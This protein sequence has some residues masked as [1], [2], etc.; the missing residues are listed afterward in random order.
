MYIISREHARIYIYIYIYIYMYIRSREPACARACV[1]LYT[2]RSMF[3]PNPPRLSGFVI[4]ATF[5]R[6]NASAFTRYS[7]HSSRLC[8]NQSSVHPPRPP[9]L[10]TLLQYYDTINKQYKTPLGLPCVYY[11]P[12][13]I[14]NHNIV[15]RPSNACRPRLPLINQSIQVL[16]R[17]TRS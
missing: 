8:T 5:L 12:Y 15:Y 9:A 2:Y 1:Y 3:T 7:I 17:Y 14:G 11:T 10:P 4:R 13:N 6:R 16:K